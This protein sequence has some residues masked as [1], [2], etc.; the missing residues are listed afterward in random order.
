LSGRNPAVGERGPLRRH[1]LVEQAKTHVGEGDARSFSAYVNEALAAKVR[2]D[3][4]RH[5]LLLS[6][7]AAA[8]DE[9]VTR[10]MRNVER[11]G[12]TAH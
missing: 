6:K 3:G 1:D 12:Q 4:R 8:D 5:A 7:A 11:Q 10:I 2:E 9:R